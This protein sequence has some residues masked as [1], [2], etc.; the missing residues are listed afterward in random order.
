ME[1][2]KTIQNAA[3]MLIGTVAVIVCLRALFHHQY[4]FYYNRGLRWV[5]TIVPTFVGVWLFM[6]GLVGII[7]ERREKGPGR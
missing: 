4:T 6:F 7:R 5:P 3:C 1:K 2:Y